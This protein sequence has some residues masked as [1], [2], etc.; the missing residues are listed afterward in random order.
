VSLFYRRNLMGFLHKGKR[1][2]RLISKTVRLT[3]NRLKRSTTTNNSLACFKG[4]LYKE[5]NKFKGNDH[6]LTLSEKR[7]ALNNDLKENNL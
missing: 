2:G 7:A 1:K 3:T 4:L 5:K 6:H